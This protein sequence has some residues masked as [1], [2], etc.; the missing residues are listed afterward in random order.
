MGGAIT[1]VADTITAGTA[2]VTMVGIAATTVVGIIIAI[3][4]EKQTIGA[5]SQ[6][7][8]ERPCYVVQS[9]SRS[10]AVAFG[11]GGNLC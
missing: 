5:R 3:G 2:V 8:S 11:W 4:G 1:A 6:V 10:T 9:E 7:P